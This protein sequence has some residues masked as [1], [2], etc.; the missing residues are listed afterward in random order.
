MSKIFI[1]TNV[2]VYAMDKADPIKQ[3]K[4]RSMLRLLQD[5]QTGVIS[6]QVL[7]EF[8][9]AGT[10][11]L[12]IAPLLIKNIIHSFGNYE[13]VIINPELIN[14]AIDCG[15]LNQLS[16]WDSLIVVAAESARCGKLWSEDLNHGQ[17]IRG[18]KIENPLNNFIN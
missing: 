1:D 16:F 6:T 18:V 17:V 8:Y 14:E 15:I 5:D 13:I 12:N 4:A 9:V 2:L 3:E 7:Q 11:K 10:Q